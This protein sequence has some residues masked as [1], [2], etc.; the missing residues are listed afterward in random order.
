MDWW[1][2]LKE[3][4]AGG[5]PAAAAGAV[6]VANDRTPPVDLG[7]NYMEA[8]GGFAQGLGSFSAEASACWVAGRVGGSAGVGRGG[9]ET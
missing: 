3:A 8:P 7:E 1:H 5:I 2:A 9:M 4:T 6:P